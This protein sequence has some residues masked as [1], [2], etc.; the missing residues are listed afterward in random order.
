MPVQ[1]VAWSESWN[2]PWQT[3][4]PADPQDP[5]GQGHHH[6]YLLAEKTHVGWARRNFWQTW[7]LLHDV[8]TVGQA[9]EA[10]LLN[11]QVQLILV[12]VL[13]RCMLQK[14]YRNMLYPNHTLHYNVNM[15]ILKISVCY[16]LVVTNPIFYKLKYNFKEILIELLDDQNWASDKSTWCYLQNKM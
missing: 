2:D 3:P 1:E 5:P 7:R 8:V 10:G 12:K 11:S 4:G 16:A 15:Y 9:V 14:L 6:H 13:C